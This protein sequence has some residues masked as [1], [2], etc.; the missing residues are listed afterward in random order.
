MTKTI[1]ISEK[2]HNHLSNLASKND[3]F[4]DVINHLID[5]YNK[6][7]EFSDEEAEFY[8]AEIEKFENGNMENVSELTLLDLEKRITQLEKEI[9]E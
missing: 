4:N 7:E 1:K 8:N 3:T 5:Y 2:T 6:N 9:K